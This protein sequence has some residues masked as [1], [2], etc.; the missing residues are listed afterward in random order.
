MAKHPAPTNSPHGRR[1]YACLGVIAATFC[2]ASSFCA[3]DI[4]E[5]C[6]SWTAVVT[7]S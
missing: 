4:G 6:G 1:G 3:P 7:R 5:S 2:Q